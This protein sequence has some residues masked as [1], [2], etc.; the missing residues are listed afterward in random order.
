MN[1]EKPGTIR[2]MPRFPRLNSKSKLFMGMC[3]YFRPYTTLEGDMQTLL[4]YDISIGAGL[5]RISRDGPWTEGQ[6]SFQIRGRLEV[7]QEP[8]L[9]SK[10]LHDSITEAELQCNKRH[11]D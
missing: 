1:N 2:Q 5:L 3:L 9:V 11:S 6:L 8:G 4:L 7:F 10:T